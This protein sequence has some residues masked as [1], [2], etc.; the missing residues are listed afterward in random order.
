MNK[1]KNCNILK[2]KVLYSLMYICGLTKNDKFIYVNC[3]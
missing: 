3:E 1:D 2:N